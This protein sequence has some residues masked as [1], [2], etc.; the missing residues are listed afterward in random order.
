MQASYSRI[1]SKIKI[2]PSN[3]V[4]GIF[5]QPPEDWDHAVKEEPLTPE[6]SESQNS[7]SSPMCS[8]QS[9]ESFFSPRMP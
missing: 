4:A 1:F 9:M 5:T 7:D 8:Q 6:S 2:F 3:V